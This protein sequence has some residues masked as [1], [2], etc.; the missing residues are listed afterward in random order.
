VEVVI[1]FLS[2]SKMKPSTST[3]CGRVC[4]CDVHPTCVKTVPLLCKSSGE[5]HGQGQKWPPIKIKQNSMV[6]Q[7][8]ITEAS[9]Q[10]LTL[11]CLWHYP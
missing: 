11:H 2:T 6:R 5:C 3:N 7:K 1:W 9:I 10:P 4:R 8:H